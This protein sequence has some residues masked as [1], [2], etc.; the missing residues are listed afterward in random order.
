VRVADEFEEVIEVDAEEVTEPEGEARSAPEGA[1][2]IAKVQSLERPGAQS[3]PAVRAAA[4]A[5]TGF[6]AGA[7]AAALVRRRSARRLSRAR[8]GET[9]EGLALLSTHTYLIRVHVLGRPA[10]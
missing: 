4:V 10:E 7:A 9:G 8:R 1:P 6:A 5:A 3:L 2:V